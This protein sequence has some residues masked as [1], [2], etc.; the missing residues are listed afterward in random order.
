M[1]QLSVIKEN[2]EEAIRLLAIKGFTKT[3]I[4][5]QLIDLDEKRKSTQ[6]QLDDFLTESNKM[7]KEIGILFKSGKTEEANQLKTKTTELKQSTKQ[8]SEELESIQKELNKLILEVPNLPHP[9][10]PAGKSDKDNEIVFEEG[11]IPTLIENAEPH[12]ELAKK[13]DIIDFDLGSKVTGAGFPFYKNQGA[14]LQRA[15]INFFLDEAYS[16]GYAEY[17]TPL[18]VNEDSAYGTGQ[19]PDKEGQMYHVTEDNF[20]L[21]PTAEVP[22]TNIYRNVILKEE[23]FPGKNHG[24]FKLFPPRSRFLRQRCSRVESPASV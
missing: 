11:E 24:L 12:W 10:V 3:E 1:L 22:L 23:R 15:L 16:K 18:F 9:S 7:A 4:L 5:D 19:L 14:R 2:K 17:Q 8:L 6:K 20:Y 13:Y 21:I